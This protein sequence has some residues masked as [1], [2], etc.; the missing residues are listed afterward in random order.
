MIYCIMCNDCYDGRLMEAWSTLAAA[1][2]R[3]IELGKRSYYIEAIRL[4]E[5]SA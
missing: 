2:A 5:K 4:N 1:E 3:L